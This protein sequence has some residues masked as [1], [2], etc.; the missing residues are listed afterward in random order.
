M[1]GI[2]V[3]RRH[4]EPETFGPAS[5]VLS[6][7]AP[8]RTSNALRRGWFGSK[9][10]GGSQQP[11]GRISFNMQNMAKPLTSKRFRRH[12]CLSI[13]VDKFLPDGTLL[14]RQICVTIKCRTRWLLNYVFHTQGETNLGVAHSNKP[15]ERV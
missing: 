1:K 6:S 13:N 15:T 12:I 14:F 11:V 5:L 7:Q 2:G 9:H 10:V 4:V 8:Q 3:P